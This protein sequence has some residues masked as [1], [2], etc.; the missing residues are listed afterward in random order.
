T[1][2]PSLDAEGRI[3][4]YI[5]ISKD[6]SERVGAELDLREQASRDPLTRLYNRRFG[7]QRL[8]ACCSD[9]AERRAELSLMICDIDHFKSIND[10]FGHAAGDLS[11]QV[12]SR[13]IQS[14]VR[15]TDIAVRWGGEEFLVILPDCDLDAA[16]TLAERIRCNLGNEA[17]SGVRSLTVSIGVA[18][19]A[20]GESQTQALARAD[21]ALYQAKRN[22]RNRVERADLDGSLSA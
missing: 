16:A 2:T 11:L 17:I 9:A 15:Q 4:H 20:A 8:L 6:V 7:E 21:K 18:S 5:S 22:G 13:I 19:L 10:T 12:C 3:D 14:S 1:I